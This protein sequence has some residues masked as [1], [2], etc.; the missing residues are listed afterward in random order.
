[1]ASHPQGGPALVTGAAGLLGQ[2]LQ[3]VLSGRGVDVRALRRDELDITDE[4]RVREAVGDLCPSVVYNCAAFTAVDL[5]EA[6]RPD[7]FR[8]NRD[9]AAN[10]AS[11]CAEAA[12]PMVH[13]STDYVFS[14]DRDRPYL[15]DD[16]PEPVNAYGASKLAGEQAVASAG[17][18]WLIA[19]TSWLFG[20]GSST[21]V[22]LMITLAGEGKRLSVVDDQTSRPTG[23]ADL[24]EAL[25]DLVS[26]G[27]QGIVHVA[28]GGHATRYELAAE[29]LRLA[30]LDA[31]IDA[32]S[33]DRFAAA[34]PRPPYSVLDISGTEAVL[35]RPMR[36]WRDALRRYLEGR[37]DPARSGGR[38]S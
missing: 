23:S 17:G 2:A 37:V 7:A 35:G 33:S 21:F 25:V 8:V 29:C 24:A 18:R 15:P 9:G 6:H 12:C 22:D 30:G 36:P 38:V 3:G 32:V 31:P 19:R 34:A 26:L 4:D 27:A 10:V 13:L 11:A 20:E 28:G 1:M 14:G 5:A 16:G